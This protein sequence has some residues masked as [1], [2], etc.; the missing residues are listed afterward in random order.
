VSI[1]DLTRVGETAATIPSSEFTITPSVI[2]KAGRAYVTIQAET[3]E[4]PAGLYEG[5]L[6][7]GTGGK[8]APALFYV[9]HA[10]LAGD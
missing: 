10:Q 3:A 4:F 8:Q 6:V 1:T 5:S 2:E 9:S 7:A